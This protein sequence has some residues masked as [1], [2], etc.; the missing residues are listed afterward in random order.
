MFLALARVNPSLGVPK[1]LCTRRLTLRLGVEWR[2]HFVRGRRLQ[3]G[4]EAPISEDGG[5]AVT[6]RD[7]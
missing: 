1:L 6:E 7:H 4:V 5:A 3:L 2:R